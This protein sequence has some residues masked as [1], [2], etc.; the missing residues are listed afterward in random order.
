VK[1]AQCDKTNPENCSSKC[2]FDCT[3]SVHNTTQNSKCLIISPLTSRQKKIWQKHFGLLF[4]FDTACTQKREGNE[5][6]RP[7]DGLGV[8]VLLLEGDF[9]AVVARKRHAVS[10]KHDV[11]TI[12]HS[13]CSTNI[14]GGRQSFQKGL[15]K[16]LTA[17]MK[18]AP[19]IYS[20]QN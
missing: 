16:G 11:L 8:F 10:H 14:W 1:W 13:D 2:A 12:S 3:A 15:R 4:F 6:N 18:P 9:E 5:T 7:R 20:A 17:G 19:N